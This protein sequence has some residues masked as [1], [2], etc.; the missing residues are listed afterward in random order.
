[1]KFNEFSKMLVSS[2][3]NSGGFGR[4]GLTL[5]VVLV[6]LFLIIGAAAAVCGEL[7]P[8]RLS[9]EFEF[10]FFVVGSLMTLVGFGIVEST[11]GRF[12][13]CKLAGAEV[14]LLGFEKLV[15]SV[16]FFEI[17]TLQIFINPSSPFS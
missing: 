5:M 11:E 17:Q 6:L 14:K 8:C 16:T 10:N 13:G 3:T 12:E 15:E 9:G 7:L 2:I 1:M 4:S